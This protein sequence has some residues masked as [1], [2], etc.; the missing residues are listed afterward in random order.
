MGEPKPHSTTSAT[1]GGFLVSSQ[2]AGC[3]A[4]CARWWTLSG[5]LLIAA[6]AC[7]PAV[8][9][10]AAT[11]A[12][13]ASATDALPPP[14]DGWPVNHWQG[15]SQAAPGR[16]LVRFKQTPAGARLSAAQAQR[17]LPGLQLR[18]LVG[19]RHTTRVPGRP[20][21]GS[22]AAAASSTGSTSLPPD[23]VM[24]FSITDGSSV[25]EKVAQL[26]A[27]PGGGA[28]SLAAF[29]LPSL[30]R[31]PL[32]CLPTTCN[33]KPASLPTS[34]PATRHWPAS[35]P[36]PPPSPFLSAAVATAQ[37]DY[38]RYAGAGAAD[39]V[40]AA[41]GARMVPDDYY[42]AYFSSLWHL[43]QI[44]APQAWDTTTGSKQVG[45]G[46]LT[47]WQC[48]LP[49]SPALPSPLPDRLA[50]LA[51]A[52]AGEGVRDR[53]WG[54]PLPPGLGWEHCWRMEQVRGCCCGGC[55]GLLPAPWRHRQRFHPTVVVAVC[56]S[57]V[58]CNCRAFK[59]PPALLFCALLQGCGPG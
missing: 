25:E 20:A 31:P 45:R 55:G 8:C 28:G 57:A 49:G 50:S 40:A 14:D 3:S 5:A 43:P 13:A 41:A 34:G 7:S 59:P 36:A 22:V 30:S 11:T 58:C 17:P 39:A 12:T 2:G 51:L 10:P 4:W 47:V 9:S 53:H 27:N 6:V 16:V 44:S 46:R 54:T 42:Y 37:P 18:R 32:P 48:L 26:R 29:C 24:L 38:I 56:C 15:R 33:A 52:A 1:R 23:A 19:K 21:S 35:H